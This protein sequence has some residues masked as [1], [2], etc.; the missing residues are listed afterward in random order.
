MDAYRPELRE[1][2]RLVVANKADL[3]GSARATEALRSRSPVPVVAVS[4]L[5]G[6][7]LAELRAALA[8]LVPGPP[9]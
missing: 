3:P 6:K 9:P 7:N 8:A 5:T 1:R 4:A 2:V